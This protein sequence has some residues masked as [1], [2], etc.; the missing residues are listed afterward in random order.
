MSEQSL[1]ASTLREHL[2][3]ES[4]EADHR[5]RHDSSAEVNQPA[6]FHLE[7]VVERVV[8]QAF[9]EMGSGPD[10][11]L[12]HI[13]PDH[14][15]KAMEF[16]ERESERRYDLEKTRHKYLPRIALILVAGCVTAVLLLCLM[17]L[18]FNK[19]EALSPILIPVLTFI[20]G[21]AGGALAGY[22]YGKRR[23]SNT[24]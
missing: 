13:T 5:L 14:L 12:R 8:E 15:T 23:L 2:P 21:L 6:E 18:A 22:G 1:P 11:I 10:P 9:V 7:S 16:A 3:L 17:F 24:K 4:E 20:S 19:V